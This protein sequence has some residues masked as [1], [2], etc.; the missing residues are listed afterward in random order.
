MISITWTD[1]NMGCG[2]VVGEWGSISKIAWMIAILKET[3]LYKSHFK[4]IH[5]FDCCTGCEL[6]PETGELADKSRRK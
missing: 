1:H 5:V 3:P 4:S 6:D 2:E